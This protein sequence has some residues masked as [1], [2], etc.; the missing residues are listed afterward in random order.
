MPDDDGQH[1]HSSAGDVVVQ[2]RVPLSETLGYSA[3]VRGL[4]SGEGSFSME[5][6]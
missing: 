4:T 5:F 6:V 2:A 3:A 1:H